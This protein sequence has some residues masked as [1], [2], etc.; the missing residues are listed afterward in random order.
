VSLDI[1]NLEFSSRDFFEIS[2]ANMRQ[3][4]K[5]EVAPSPQF[6]PPKTDKPRP[7]L[8]T[9]C[10][11]SFARLE[12]LKRHERSHTKEKPFECDQC[13]RCFAR[14]DL[15][16]RH[17]QKL[18]QNVNISKP[19]A[20][21][22]ESTSGV[23]PGRS[24]K[25]S[26]AG[27]SPYPSG[28]MP[29]AP[30][31]PRANTISHIDGNSLNMLMSQ[32]ASRPPL[33]SFPSHAMAPMMDFSGF[34]FR[35]VG[36]GQVHSSQNLPKIS[37]AGL[38]LDIG[39]GLKTAPLQSFHTTDKMFSTVNPAQLH[40]GSQVG[41]P[42]SPFTQSF[43]PFQQTPQ[44]D[45]MVDW[46]ALT[47]T[48]I[49]AAQESVVD[50]SSPSAMSTGSQSGFSEVMIDGSNK[51]NQSSDWTNQFMLSSS[52]FSADPIS[53]A[54]FP[55]LVETS[56]PVTSEL[57]QPT[58]QQLLAFDAV[59]ASSMNGTIPF[60]A[61]F[62]MLPSNMSL[63]PDGSSYQSPVIFGNEQ[64]PHAISTP[65][66]NSIPDWANGLGRD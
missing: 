17:Q 33:P 46:L 20:A 58:H 30:M 42:A 45:D 9:T 44:A 63:G 25:S 26:V 48:N 53:A 22:R 65:S 13:G 16:L 5:D 60:P 64:H 61:H 10:M 51:P 19:R 28:Q 56:M 50:G 36:Y 24:R 23:H 2:V 4:G 57:M 35:P 12:H 3:V 8:C 15:L 31:R 39:G 47:D 40:F 59:T 43:P 55:E 34:D 52:H 49:S 6:P 32:N 66:S 38:G 41:T 7:H 21:R 37:T 54:V 27:V 1:L 18:H 14:R 62:Q 29:R 11:R